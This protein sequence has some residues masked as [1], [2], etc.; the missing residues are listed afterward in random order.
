MKPGDTLRRR[1]TRCP[2]LRWHPKCRAPG[3]V[4]AARQS[5]YYTIKTLWR[6]KRRAFGAL[7]ASPKP[8]GGCCGICNCD[9]DSARS[10]LRVPTM[11]I[12]I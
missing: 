9:V 2:R 6:F 11:S 1:P 12:Y 4:H 8:F 7:S 10:A 5:L 3:D